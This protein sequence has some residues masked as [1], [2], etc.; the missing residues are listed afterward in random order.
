MTADQPPLSPD[1]GQSS[2][3]TPGAVVVPQVGAGGAPAAPV[4]PAPAAGAGQSA[5]AGGEQ[6]KDEMKNIAEALAR[7][8]AMKPLEGPITDVYSPAEDKKAALKKLRDAYAA[9]ITKDGPL[10]TKFDAARKSFD[11]AATDMNCGSGSAL[12]KWLEYAFGA[13]GP[14]KTLLDWREVLK[15]KV[16]PQMG[17]K[18][19][20]RAEAQAETKK[21]AARYADWSAPVDKITA[22]IGQYAD[23]IDKLNAD[24]NNEV[25][26]NV[27]MTT[28]WFEVAT[29]HL[30]LES[31]LSAEVKAA[32]D[33]V[34]AKLTSYSDLK[35]ILKLG[36]ERADESLYLVATADEAEAKRR[37]VL[38]KWKAAAEKQA[39]AEADFKL[40]PDDLAT[41]KTRWDKLK[42][43]AW[44]AEAKKIP[45]P[46]KS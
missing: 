25:N 38:V 18:E 27:A 32:V 40:N 30:Q 46:S 37:T 23:K 12:D 19:Q 45:E 11:R 35:E 42:D 1:D 22:Q 26:R 29:R 8:E 16:A 28:F 15:S 13:N 36:N 41:Y 44:I 39:E 31:K 34:A 21:W 20:A 33:K 7:A 43:D 3:T 5:S 24:I 14:Y 9:A 4:A 2:P 17:P 10:R 6:V